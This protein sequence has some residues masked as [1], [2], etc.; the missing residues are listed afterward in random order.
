[1]NQATLE[2]FRQIATAMLGDQNWQW[3]G[4]HMSQRMFGVSRER[5]ERYAKQYGGQAS[6][7]PATETK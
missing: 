3:I 4:P 7:M 1:M 2:G 5:A 6:Q